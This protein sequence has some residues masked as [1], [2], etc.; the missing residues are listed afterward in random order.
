MARDEKEGIC[1]VETEGSRQTDRSKLNGG[2]K[3]SKPQIK[4][5][6]YK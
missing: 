5:E 3:L 4:K 1:W 6:I 2:E